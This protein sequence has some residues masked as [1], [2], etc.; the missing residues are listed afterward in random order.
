MDRRAGQGRYKDVHT[1]RIAIRGFVPRT[2]IRTG[3]PENR[4]GV[5]GND[6]TLKFERISGG[7]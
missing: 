7:H 6:T 1:D 2:N 3:Y 4:A 5:R